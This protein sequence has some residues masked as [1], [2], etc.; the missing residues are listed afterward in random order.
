MNMKKNI[1]YR[2]IALVGILL[3]SSCNSFLNIKP[4][5]ELIPENAEDYEAMLN[6]GNVLKTAESYPSFRTD[7]AYIP[8]ES[9]APD[10]FP[11]TR[12]MSATLLAVYTFEKDIFGDAETDYYYTQAYE[13]IFY[14]NVI[15]SKIMD[16]GEATEAQKLSIRS[17]AYMGRAMEYLNLINGYAVQYDAKT[18]GTDL[19]VPLILSDDISVQNLTRATVK[20]VYDQIINDLN[21]ALKYLGDRPKINAFRASK[22]A[23]LGILARTYLYMG[24]Y[25]NALKYSLQGLSLRSTLLDMKK[26]KVI[27]PNRAIGRTNLPTRHDNPENIFIRLA[28]YV[29]GNSKSV[30]ASKDLLDIFDQKHDQRFAL[31]YSNNP[32]GIPLGDDYLYL[33]YLYANLGITTPEMYLTAAECEA[34]LGQVNA[35]LRHLNTL[36]EN[37]ILGNTPLNITDKE[38]LLVEVLKERRREF[39]L[40]GNYRFIDLRRLNKEDKFA[41]TVTHKAGDKTYTLEPNSPRYTLQFPNKVMRMNEKSLVPNP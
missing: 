11:I 33:P 13:N 2:S 29:F 3:M 39:A 6:A 18:A 15:I 30:Y 40:I 21:E 22:P 5:G 38:D 26:Y 8:E 27:Y 7:D 9:P 20:E 24:D 36:R 37:R 1:I 32:F 14:Y 34:R 12:T 35:A 17:E 19:G 25:E 23:A 10:F 41:K 28:P 4:K 31:Y 16:S